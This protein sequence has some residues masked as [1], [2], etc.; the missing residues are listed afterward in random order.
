[1]IIP[2]YWD[3]GVMEML[4][5]CINRLNVMC[6]KIFA[7]TVLLL[8]VMLMANRAMFFHTHTLQDGTV[9]QHAHPYPVQQ[10]Q[11]NQNQ[12]QHNAYEFLFYAQIQTALFVSLLAVFFIPFVTGIIENHLRL[13]TPRRIVVHLPLLR[14]PPHYS[15][16]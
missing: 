13:F 3:C 11:Q 16:V 5:F 12:H 14:A 6:K 8:V 15:F 2:T 10:E 9:V 7:Y 4:Y 1:M